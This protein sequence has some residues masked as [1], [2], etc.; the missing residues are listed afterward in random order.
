MKYLW[1]PQNNAWHVVSTEYHFYPSRLPMA[2]KIASWG[3]DGP[4][5]ADTP[6]VHML[7]VPEGGWYVFTFLSSWGHGSANL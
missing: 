2:G 3:R 6:P 4:V 1:G 7:Q 5:P